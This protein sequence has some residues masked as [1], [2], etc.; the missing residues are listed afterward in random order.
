MYRDSGRDGE[1]CVGD[2]G[3]DGEGCVGIVEGW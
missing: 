1:G 3:R 2:S